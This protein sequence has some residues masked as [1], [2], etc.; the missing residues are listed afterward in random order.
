MQIF[1]NIFYSLFYCKLLLLWVPSSILQSVLALSIIFLALTIFLWQRRIVGAYLLPRSMSTFLW[2]LFSLV[3][4]FVNVL[5]IEGNVVSAF[6][7]IMKFI[8]MLCI[9]YVFHSDPSDTILKYRYISYI[10]LIH[11]IVAIIGYPLGLGKEYGGVYRPHGIAGTVNILSNLA[12]FSSAYFGVK[13]VYKRKLDINLFILISS[14]IVVFISGTLKNVLVLMV[15]PVIYV[16]LNSKN[17]VKSI[18]FVILIFIPLAYLFIINTAISERMNEVISSGIDVQAT[19]G[20]QLGSSAAWRVLHWKLLLMDWWNNYTLNGSGI[21]QVVYMNALKT[22][23]GTGFD[24]HSDWIGFFVELGPVLFLSF[25][26]FNLRF[27]YN[28]FTIPRSSNSSVD[29]LFFAFISLLV[30]MSFG[31][32]V[33][34]VAYFYLFWALYG[35]ES[36]HKNVNS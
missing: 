1:Y 27:L 35:L 16:V 5:I 18:L 20:D 6:S 33:Y 23:K 15:L 12:L 24:A 3:L 17:K 7:D 21:G 26:Y 13:F 11:M 8:T 25:A 9:F 29:A 19:Q 34:S 30:S 32:V 28:I 4:S 10:I 2:F 22:I 36:K 31:P 14:F